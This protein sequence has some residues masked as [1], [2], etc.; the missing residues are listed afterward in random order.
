IAPQT[1]ADFAFLLHDLYHLKPDGI[2]TIL[3]PHGVLFRGGEEEKIRKNLVEYNNIDAI[4]GLPTNIFFNTGIPTIIIIL[5]QERER[6]DVLMI[7]ASKHFIKAGKSNRLQASDIKRIVDCVT[8]RREIPKFSRIVPKSEIV[9]NGYN[10]NIPRYVDSAAEAETWDIFAIMHGG[11][12]K[13][14]LVQFADYWQAFDGLQN[15]LFADNGTPY[16]QPKTDNLKAAI[17]S[18]PSVAAFQADFAKNFEDFTACLED[19]LI[20]PMATVNIAQ[21]Q[22]ALAER[23]REKLAATPLMDFYIAYQKLDDLWRADAAGIAAD[24]EMIQSEGTQAIK[25]VDANMVLKKDNKTQ[26]EAEVQ[27]G[28]VGRILPFELVQQ[29]K[30]PDALARLKAQ[31]NRLAEIDGEMQSILENLSEEEKSGA[32]VNDN[33]DAFVAKE[34][35]AYFKMIYANITTEE[36]QALESYLELLENKAKKPEKLAF[37]QNNTAVHWENIEASKDGTYAKAKINAYLKTLR[38]NYN[39]DEDSLESKLLKAQALLDEE[40]SLKSEIKTTAAKLHSDTKAIIENLSDEEA[41]DLLRQKWFTPLNQAMFE[42]PETMLAAFGQKLTALCAKYANTYQDIHE[43]RQQSATTLANMMDD[44][45][46]DDFDMK[47]I[48]AWQAALKG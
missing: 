34:I 41:L 37:I 20:K 44:L 10:L 30:L 42:L 46:G 28:W 7:D 13:A 25:Q 35:T 15:A 17:Q 11:V 22:Q 23:I 5:R 16:V 9:A 3:L 21:T 33:N 43:R 38:S 4:V 29:V 18:H 6:D 14:E 12:P 32:Y 27:D 31:E 1:K 36:T 45:T 2:M 40:K 47:G 48:A 24:L 19:M 8:G 39:F 26:K